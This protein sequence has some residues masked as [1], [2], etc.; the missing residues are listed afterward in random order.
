MLVENKKT[1]DSVELVAN[2]VASQVI[3]RI[4]VPLDK[5]LWDADQCADYLRQGRRTFI[6]KTSKHHTFPQ[7]IRVPLSINETT[8]SKARAVWNA[9][10]VIDWANSW[11]I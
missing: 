10:E 5:T 8:E 11:K 2:K 6:D 3:A 9:S 7:A 4:S 1:E